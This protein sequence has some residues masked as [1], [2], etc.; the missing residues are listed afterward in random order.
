MSHFTNDLV[1]AKSS[2]HKGN[3]YDYMR[4][5]SQPQRRNVLDVELK[6]YSPLH[7]FSMNLGFSPPLTARAFEPIFMTD[8]FF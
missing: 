3:K 2:Y 8:Y 7:E 5:T 1:I 6:P 4:Y